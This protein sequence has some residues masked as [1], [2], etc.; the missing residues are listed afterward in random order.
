MRKVIFYIATSL[1][2]YIAD[3][4]GGI[5]WLT[6]PVE[7]PQPDNNYEDF[8]RTVDTVI[9]GRTTYDQV[10]TELSPKHYPYADVTSYVMTT[11]PLDDHDNI[12]FTNDNIIDLVTRL[13]AQTGKTIWVVGGSAVAKPL[14]E[15][16]L[17]DEYHLAIIPKILGDGIPL[18]PQFS[19]TPLPFTAKESYIK[20]NIV[21]QVFTK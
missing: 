18:F 3:T 15:H 20:N 21:Y 10:T 2:G 8:Y 11:K 12:Y 7:N 9:L 16:N 5:D 4:N 17:I 19:T 13:K 6:M 14:I 1:D